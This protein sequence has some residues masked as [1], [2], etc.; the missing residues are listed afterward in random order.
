MAF[1]KP[2][3][4]DV[5]SFD[6]TES[7]KIYFNVTGGD[8]HTRALVTIT[9]RNTPN[10][11]YKQLTLVA[12]HDFF[13]LEANTLENNKYYAMVLQIGDGTT[14]SEKSPSDY[15]S[16]FAKSTISIND[17]SPDGTSVITKRTY[18][19]TGSYTQPDDPLS[20]YRFFVYNEDGSLFYDS[21]NQYSRIIS[22]QVTNFENET[23]YDILLEVVSQSGIL[24][25]TG[26][27]PFRVKFQKTGIESQMN[28]IGDPYSGDV[29]IRAIIKDQDG[30][31]Y[32]YMNG[33]LYET[34]D[35]P[36]FVTHKDN[37]GVGTR[38]ASIPSNKAVLFATDD[39]FVEVYTLTIWFT[40]LNLSNKIEIAKIYCGEST[41]QILAAPT[42]IELLC[43]FNGRETIY[44][45][46][47][48]PLTASVNE[49]LRI[50]IDD[51]WPKIEYLK[52]GSIE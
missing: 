41:I 10:I 12:D 7:Q 29:S 3:L 9:E 23:N 6:A 20:Y 22:T 46:D 42:V 26:K 48:E 35:D 44:H 11:I 24:S 2:V 5:I 34:K 21:G 30:E 43:D 51:C 47:I 4:L 40:R 14:W 39:Y 52:G 1:N 28:V 50:T 32:D 25:T 13:V 49:L 27:I 38:W 15:F 37:D 8:L 45:L 16:C 18:T 33:V 19:F 36:Q 31:L 17:V